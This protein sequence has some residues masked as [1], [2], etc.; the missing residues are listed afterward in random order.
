MFSPLRFVT[1]LIWPSAILA[2]FAAAFNWYD[3]SDHIDRVFLS[4][5][6]FQ[7]LL[8]GMLT[9]N[10]FSKI[11]LGT[12][13]AFYRAD[14]TQFGIRL[15][16][17]V[18]PRFFIQRGPIRE[19]SFKAQRACYSAPLLTKLSMFSGGLLLWL[20]LSRSGSGAADMFLAVAVGGFGSFLFTLNPLWPADGYRWLAAFLKRPTLRQQSLRLTAMILTGKR[21]PAGLSRGE[22]WALVGYAVL[23]AGFT[24]FL[25][26]L[27][28]RGIAFALEAQLRG[29]GVVIFCIILAMVTLFLISLRSRKSSRPVVRK[30]VKQPRNAAR[31]PGG[32]K[33]MAARIAEPRV[34]SAHQADD[35]VQ[36]TDLPGTPNKMSEKPKRGA[37]AGLAAKQAPDDAAA[38]AQQPSGTDEAALREVFGDD[39]GWGQPRWSGGEVEDDPDAFFDGARPAGGTDPDLDDLFA[40][41]PDDVADLDD[42]PI[43][44]ELEQILSAALEEEEDLDPKAQAEVISPSFTAPRPARSRAQHATPV[45]P[46]LEDLF[47]DDPEDDADLDDDP[48]MDELEAILSAELEGDLPDFDLLDEPTPAAPAGK[49]TEDAPAD[50]WEEVEAKAP[51]APATPSASAPEP[52]TPPQ[53]TAAAQPAALP[54]PASRRAPAQLPPPKPTT[55]AAPKRKSPPPARPRSSTEE[56]DRVLN[57]GAAARPPRNKWRARIIWA[58]LLIGLIYVAMMPYAFEVGGEFTIQPLELSQVRA[59]TDGEITEVYVSEGDWVE[60]GQILAVL[61]NWDEKRDIAVREAEIA[62]LQAELETL[63]S[64]ARPEEIAVAEQSVESADL[65]IAIAAR[66]LER[67]KQLFASGTITKQALDA[68]ESEHQIAVAARQE[69]LAALEL[70]RSGARES[71]IAAARANIARNEEDLAFSRL[72]LEQTHIRAA[73]EG[74]IVS[75]LDAVPVGAFL[76][77]GGLFAQLENNRVVLAEIEV[78]ETEIDEVAIDAEVLLK[79]W[80]STN[81]SLTGTVYRVAPKAEERDFGRVIRVV[82]KVPNV[83]GKLSSNMTG[84][85]KVSAEERPVWEAFS[86]VIVRFF[87]VELWSWLP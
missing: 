21:I 47:A 33:V 51:D 24:A 85:A 79:L 37:K 82:V 53:D 72:Q 41:D 38:P 36:E 54:V 28:L 6:F 52:E 75:S 56:L 9:A 25:I 17:G 80:S 87:Q 62:K 39:P 31:D 27:V 20:M 26:Y 46:D 30:A 23:S 22:A 3:L 18:I 73:S 12:T 29:T 74:Q 43:M 68:A 4:I 66:E 65:R 34:Y 57:I 40:D 10:L 1:W 84:F 59:R 61:S 63:I 81:D 16:F 58:L 86:R 44:D 50:A 45:H 7:N 49:P 71:E 70:V 42:D 83:E 76:P 5:G 69:A 19:L 48:I 2:G 11:M 78:P 15:L 35:P 13:M 8:I 67:Q 32:T 64:G 14:S 60:K 77:E 55:P